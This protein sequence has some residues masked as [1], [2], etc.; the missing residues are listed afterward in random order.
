[1]SCGESEQA[2]A[3]GSEST[4]PLVDR[5]LGTRARKAVDDVRDQARLIRLGAKAADKAR[6]TF[7]FLTLRGL[8]IFGRENRL[9]RRMLAN[10]A[11]TWLRQVRIRTPAG[12]MYMG[13]LDTLPLLL[14]SFEPFAS[15]WINFPSGGT[16]VDVGAHFGL[17]TI[18]ASK[19]VG[20]T[21]RVVAIEP[22]PYANSFLRKSIALNG[23]RNVTL[24]TCA[25]W[26]RNETMRL[27]RGVASG[28]N[29]LVEQGASRY[30]TS[31]YDL[32]DAMRLDAI[33]REV[34]VSHVDW[35]KIDV[36]G[37]EVEVLHGLG[38]A[39]NAC[40]RIMVEVRSRNVRA[41]KEYARENG[42]HPIQIS[43]WMEDTVYLMLIRDCV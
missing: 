41:V 32:V 2:S 8:R 37:A 1:M 17:Y 26:S 29:S 42:F 35:L 4:R 18:P 7:F 6:L 9:R 20:E 25:C 40:R 30:V 33:L 14:P 36:E 15:A 23:A 11:R 31:D 38:A 12:S 27:Y 24:L 39:A 5:T 22:N 21:G 3:E 28:N 19:R 13:D 16:V 43:A 34:G 10:G